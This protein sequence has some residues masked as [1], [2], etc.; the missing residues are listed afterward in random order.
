[1]KTDAPLAG[2]AVCAHPQRLR[3][4]RLSGNVS[5]LFRDAQFTGNGIDEI[6]ARK[7]FIRKW[8][9]SLKRITFGVAGSP[10]PILPTENDRILMRL[11]YDPQITPGL[12]MAKAMDIVDKVLA[13]RPKGS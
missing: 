7:L 12:P 5:Q 1:M 9:N 11:L 4:S 13:A 2:P 3:D 8:P 6:S 10:P